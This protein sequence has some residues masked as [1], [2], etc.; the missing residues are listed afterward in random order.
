M[1]A[2]NLL[3]SLVLLGFAVCY[4]LF[5]GDYRNLL[6]VLQRI[7]GEQIAAIVAAITLSVLLG[8]ARLRALANEFGY[9]LRFATSVQVVAVSQAAANFFFQIYGQI[10]SRGLLLK[11]HGVPYS[12]TVLLTLLERLVGLSVLLLSAALGALLVFGR[13]TI[14]LNQGGAELM[15]TAVGLSLALASALW[16]LQRSGHLRRGIDALGEFVRARAVVLTALYTI[17]IQ[18]A[19]LF[20]FTVSA[21]VLAPNISLLNLAAAS[22]VVMLASALPI[23]FGGWGIR[24][25]SAVVV[26]GAVGVAPEAAFAAAVLIGVL[27]LGVVVAMG[28]VAWLA[29]VAVGT[30]DTTARG[31]SIE[32]V[33]TLTLLGCVIPLL[34]AVLV[35]F[36]I[37]VP[38]GS[39]ALNVCIA[40]PLVVI[41]AGLF[42]LQF[43]RHE[44]DWTV[45]RLGLYAVACAAVITVGYLHGWLA[46]GS[47]SWAATKTLGWLVLISYA[48]S[49]A[50][51]VRLAGEAGRDAAFQTL[52]GAVLG[53]AL[54]EYVRFVAAAQS[55]QLPI[56]YQVRAAGFAQDPNALGF[57]ILVVIAVALTMCRNSAYRLCALASCLVLLWL[58]GS[59]SAALAAL[60]LVAFAL[61]FQPRAASTVALAVLIAGVLLFV[62]TLHIGAPTLHIGGEKSIGAMLQYRPT[63]I[64]ERLAT[65]EIAWQLFQSHPWL[66]TGLGYFVRFFPRPDGSNLIIHSTYLWL[67]AEFG[68]IGFAVF[69]ASALDLWRSVWRRAW[70]DRGCRLALLVL[71]GLGTMS[72]VHDMLFQRMA[73]FA[74]GLA[75]ARTGLRPHSDGDPR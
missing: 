19:T 20:S 46:F 67:L 42:L 5:Y 17:A 44:P 14:N 51:I 31:A 28:G 39:G 12:T 18:A 68:L 69:G 26:L 43:S 15:R 49:G 38:V 47:N 16:A 13:I 62:P 50:L 41:G 58:S 61:Y 73:Y 52:I 6:P 11:P 66:G 55:L 8:A 33:E 72:L 65:M 10:I 75:L 23:S 54:L 59:R 3:V 63:S 56:P 45:G 27:S 71:A 9:P 48:M 35:F 30:A 74:L 32:R 2:A 21:V 40:D 4:T 37:H 25:F 60:V 22:T 34:I 29:R 24:E 57:Q 36:Q 64:G 7:S 53:I 1:S 70:V